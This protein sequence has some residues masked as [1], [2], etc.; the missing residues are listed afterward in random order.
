M[1]SPGCTL[2]GP[3]VAFPLTGAKADEREVLL[4]LLAFEPELV[5]T[6]PVPDADGRQ[7]LLRPRI[8]AGS[9]SW[10]SGCCGRLARASPSDPDTA[11]SRRSAAHRIS[12]QHPQDP[13]RPRTPRRPNPRR[14]RRT[15]PA[16]HP[17]P[18]RRHLAQPQDRTTALYGHWSP[19]TIDLGINHRAE[20]AG[21]LRAPDRNLVSCQAGRELLPPF[22]SLGPAQHDGRDNQHRRQ[23]HGQVGEVGTVIDDDVHPIHR[24]HRGDRQVRPQSGEPFGGDGHLGVG[25]GLAELDHPRPQGSGVL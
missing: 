6:R 13:A 25:P 2:D 3:A 1:R 22:L 5:A 12:Q 4:E 14:S 7:E 10:Q 19:T 11:S 20:Q 17:R 8:R 21:K 24:R 15:R 18:H 16:T 23:H 9:P